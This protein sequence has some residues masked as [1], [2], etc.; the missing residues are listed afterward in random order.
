MRIGFFATFLGCGIER[1]EAAFLQDADGSEVVP[2]DSGVKGAA[3]FQLQKRGERLGG[4]APA[5]QGAIK[6][7]ADLAVPVRVPA[8]DVPGDLL[9]GFPGP[10]SDRPNQARFVGED[11]RPMPVE[12]GAI[13]RFEGDHRHRDGVA[14]VFEEQREVAGF[15]WTQ[16]NVNGL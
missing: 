6:P 15:D 11:L 9:C 2:G 10:D 8:R 14:L 1:G 16:S 5:P 7:V 13:A 12:L 4:N 3:L